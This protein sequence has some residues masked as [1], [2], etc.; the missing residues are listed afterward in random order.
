MRLLKVSIIMF[1]M[2][3]QFIILSPS[4]IS[5]INYI[6]FTKLENYLSM[7][8]HEHPFYDTYLCFVPLFL[9]IIVESGIKLHKYSWTTRSPR[10]DSI[11][12]HTTDSADESIIGSG[13]SPT[14]HIKSELLSLELLCDCAFLYILYKVMLDYPVRCTLFLALLYC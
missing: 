3:L 4:I 6:L 14:G 9:R 5:V 8:R 10:V 13:W 12:Y 7:L 2:V 1:L 11:H